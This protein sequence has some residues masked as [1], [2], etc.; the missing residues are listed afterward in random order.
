LQS[1]TFSP[2]GSDKPCI[3][4]ADQQVS[5]TGSTSSDDCFDEFTSILPY[6][7]IE[8]PAS[9]LTV[10]LVDGAAN[11]TRN[12]ADCRDACRTEPRCQ[13][14]VFRAG[15]DNAAN[16]GCALKLE[17]HNHATDTYTAFKLGVGDYTVFQ[18]C[19]CCLKPTCIQV[20]CSCACG[21]HGSPD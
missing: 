18:V 13:Y 7:F 4:C 16:N 9:A 1:G 11:N 14:W 20:A 10:L 19:C 15:Q 6:D 5:A 8:T 12:A 21:L 17:P 3:P 2:G